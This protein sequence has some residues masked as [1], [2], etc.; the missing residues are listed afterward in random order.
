[1]RTVMLAPGQLQ[2]E[3]SQ[4]GLAI[5][6]PAFLSSLFFWDVR[7]LGSFQIRQGNARESEKEPELL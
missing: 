3:G 4:A 6:H 1:M 5:A 2:A 7:N